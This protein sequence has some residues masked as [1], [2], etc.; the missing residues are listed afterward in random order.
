MY[1][2]DAERTRRLRDDSS[3]D[4]ARKL[5]AEPT[6]RRAHEEDAADIMRICCGGEAGRQE[7][8]DQ[9]ACEGGAQEAQPG[10]SLEVEKVKA[11]DSSEDDT[12]APAAK[13]KATA[14]PVQA[15]EAQLHTKKPPPP[16]KPKGKATAQPTPAKP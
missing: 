14:T 16:A 8:Q 6:W 3:E 9:E 7:A 2:Y 13:A 15:K 10:G 4:E 12:P 5:T 11:V 1:V